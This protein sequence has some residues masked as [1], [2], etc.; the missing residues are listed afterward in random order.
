MVTVTLALSTRRHCAGIGLLALKA[1]P[2]TNNSGVVVVVM[3][4][5]AMALAVA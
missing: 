2:A 5:D 4:A 1:K 3:A